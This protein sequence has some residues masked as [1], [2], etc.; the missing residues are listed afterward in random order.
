MNLG[1]GTRA[2]VDAAIERLEAEFGSVPVE[3]VTVENDPEFFEAGVKAAAEG[4]LGGAGAWVHDED[5]RVLFIRHPNDPETWG[6]PGGGIEPG[7]TLAETAVREV[8]EETG[9]RARVTGVWKVRHRTI[10]HRD[11]PERRLYTFDVWFDAVAAD[12]TGDPDPDAWEADEEIL[13]AR[14]FEDAPE[15]VYEPFE[16]RIERWFDE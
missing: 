15:F 1:D 2:S 14:W 6:L 8:R 3:R 13:A 12:P 10:R 7:E 16:D 11:D 4:T 9:V 5:D